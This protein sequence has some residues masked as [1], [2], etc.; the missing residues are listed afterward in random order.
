MGEGFAYF[1]CLQGLL[2]RGGLAVGVA[3]EVVEVVLDIRGANE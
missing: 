2:L 3:S 1:L